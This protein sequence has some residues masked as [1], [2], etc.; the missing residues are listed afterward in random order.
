M[1]LNYQPHAA[2][3]EIHRAR[4]KQFGTVCTGMWV[5]ASF[6]L[7]PSSGREKGGTIANSAF[8]FYRKAIRAEWW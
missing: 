2:Q 6:L 8:A 4:G 5:H 1:S 7:V 3:L